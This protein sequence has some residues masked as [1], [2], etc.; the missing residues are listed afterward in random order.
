MNSKWES[1]LQS[2]V[3]QIQICS[4]AVDGKAEETCSNR[5]QFLLIDFMSDWKRLAEKGDKQ[6]RANQHVGKQSYQATKEVQDQIRISK[7]SALE[8]AML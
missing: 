1:K 7:H 6:V 2:C 4:A 3:E 5:D 8:K